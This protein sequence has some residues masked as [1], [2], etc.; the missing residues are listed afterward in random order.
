MIGRKEKEYPRSAIGPNTPLTAPQYDQFEAKEFPV[1]S[2][3]VFVVV[4]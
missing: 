2:P 3:I 4:R 1:D